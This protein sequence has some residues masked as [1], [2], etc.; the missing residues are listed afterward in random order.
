[1][2]N[3]YTFKVFVAIEVIA[4]DEETAREQLDEK[5]GYLSDRKVELVNVTKVPEI[6]LDKDSQENN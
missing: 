3:V 1:M 5:G 2:T 4:P 6:S